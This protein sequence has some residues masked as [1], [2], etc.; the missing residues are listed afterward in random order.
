MDLRT[1]SACNL[2]VLFPALKVYIYMYEHICIH[3]ISNGWYFSI[4]GGHG[5][6]YASLVAWY[7]SIVLFHDHSQCCHIGQL[8]LREVATARF[9]H[10]DR[11]RGLLGH[12]KPGSFGGFGKFQRLR[13]PTAVKIPWN[14]L[15]FFVWPL[16]WA[17]RVHRQTHNFHLGF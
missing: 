13:I 6:T 3:M 2:M 9:C 16:L 4:W 17:P 8:R 14:A 11:R 1:Y 10:S 5:G 15:G 7:F 12:L